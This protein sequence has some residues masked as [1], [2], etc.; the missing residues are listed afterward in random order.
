M[1]GSQFPHIFGD[2]GFVDLS[3][4]AV[5]VLSAWLP[6][7]DFIYRPLSVRV[8]L[9]T[10]AVVADRLLKLSLE[11][12]GGGALIKAPSTVIQIASEVKSYWASQGGFDPNPVG[13]DYSL[14]LPVA[15]FGAGDQLHIQV[16]NFDAG[17]QIS[18]VRISYLKWRV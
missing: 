8:D 7:G 14:H 17:D 2:Y 11:I 4:P 18:N 9:S 10:S 3:D 13:D 15:Y 16:D 6:S 1:S 5:G 12:P